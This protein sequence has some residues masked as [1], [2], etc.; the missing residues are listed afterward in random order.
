MPKYCEAS[1]VNVRVAL[2]HSFPVAPRVPSVTPSAETLATSGMAPKLPSTWTSM[3]APA[4]G[5]SGTGSLWTVC[6]PNVL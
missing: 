6:P 3:L 5:A 4:A 2:P 1:S